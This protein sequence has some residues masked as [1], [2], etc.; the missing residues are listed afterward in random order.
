MNDSTRRKPLPVAV[1][2]Y[3]NEAVSCTS[4]LD[5]RIH[6]ADRHIWLLYKWDASHVVCLQ[7]SRSLGTLSTTRTATITF[8]APRMFINGELRSAR[9]RSQWLQSSLPDFVPISGSSQ[10][11]V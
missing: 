2:G 11:R 8:G 4:A 3:E 1:L 7:G 6:Y 9:E 10:M 5:Q